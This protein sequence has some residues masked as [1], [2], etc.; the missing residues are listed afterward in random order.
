[1]LDK[2]IR[3]ANELDKLGLES[4]ANEIDNII[5]NCAGM[6][7]FFKR[8]KEMSPEIRSAVEKFFNKINKDSRDALGE[9][10]EIKAEKE[11]GLVI[12]HAMGVDN[13][14]NCWI[15]TPE[16]NERHNERLGADIP[17][18]AWDHGMPIEG[19]DNRIYGEW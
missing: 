2:L 15:V 19:S 16:D 13:T 5:I 11:D 10:V 17:H 14:L 12:Y 8:E 18:A 1:M 3:L 4:G 7:D 9:L 6:F